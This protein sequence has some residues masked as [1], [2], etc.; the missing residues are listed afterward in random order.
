MNFLRHI[1]G[2]IRE[3]RFNT[4]S[5]NR[6]EILCTRIMRFLGIAFS[7]R[8]QMY[9]I[10]SKHFFQQIIRLSSV[11]QYFRT[12]RQI[13]RRLFKTIQ[14][15]CVARSKSKFHRNTFRCNNNMYFKTISERNSPILW[16][17]RL[18]LLLPTMY[19]YE[20]NKDFYQCF[21]RS[22]RLQSGQPS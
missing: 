14:I 4:L 1:F 10:I 11:S 6:Y 9:I 15:M 18:N 7:G 20:R 8:F 2:N 19:G 13:H 21:H 3:S 5:L 22:I 17:L 12:F 16:S